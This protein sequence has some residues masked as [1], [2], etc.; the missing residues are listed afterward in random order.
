MFLIEHG[1]VRM[2]LA[3]QAR[4]SGKVTSYTT[5]S[6]GQY[7]YSFDLMDRPIGLTDLYS[8]QWMQGVQYGPS[9]QIT[10]R[11]RRWFNGST[12]VNMTETRQYNS[13]GQLTR[14]TLPGVLDQEYDYSS[15][16][17]NGRIT[18]TIDHIAGETVSYTYDSLNRLATA[19]SSLGWGESYTYDGFGNLTDETVTAGSAPP[20]HVTVDPTTNR[21]TG[22]ACTYDANGN[23][24]AVAGAFTATYNVNN[25]PYTISPSSGGTQV[26][27]YDQKWRSGINRRW[28]QQHYRWRFLRSLRRACKQR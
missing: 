4:R 3:S 15:I 7:N 27:Y 21:L 28:L 22:S 10:Q 24:T 20:L 9:D 6:W 14:I 19:T 11:T 5:P 12:Y 13:L 25:K 26:Y 1:W 23:L 18:Q 2:Q 17:N 16:K 8:T